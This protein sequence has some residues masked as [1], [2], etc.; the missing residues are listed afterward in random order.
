MRR[1]RLAAVVFIAAFVALSAQACAGTVSEQW[2]AGGRAVVYDAAPGEYNELSIMLQSG[3]FT[4]QDGTLGT[5]DTLYVQAQPPCEH[6]QTPQPS[7]GLIDAFCPASGV[8]R[9]AVVV[10]D[11]NDFV[12]IGGMTSTD[13][14]SAI[15]AGDGADRV[16]GGPQDD[17][18][19]GG[20]GND[21]LTGNAGRDELFGDAGDDVIDA[22]DGVPDRIFCGT[23][24]DIVQA[25]PV[26][27][28]AA[29]CEQVDIVGSPP[30][31][32]LPQVAGAG[33]MASIDCPA[34]CRARSEL[35]LTGAR[36]GRRRLGSGQ[37]ARVGAGR[38]MLRTRLAH[39]A[40]LRL[41]RLKRPRI[42]LRITVIAGETST[43][44]MRRGI[45]LA[46]LS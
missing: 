45:G 32:A 5:R 2:V 35:L 12:S 46:D 1:C 34:T 25:D 22:A 13:Y 14:P 21:T 37:A 36:P 40:A 41:S 20:A 31:A 7:T 30:P 38:L 39:G 4:I 28:V 6:D 26:D 9:I 24:Y 17:V 11:G 18:I 33:L 23:G 19:H 3:Q 42:T 43:T 10:G 44:V 16:W 15:D 8:S 29:D 27:S